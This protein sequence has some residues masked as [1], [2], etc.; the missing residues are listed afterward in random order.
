MSQSTFTGTRV[1]DPTSGMRALGRN[2]VEDFAKNMNYFAE[3]DALCHILKK[4]YKVK[5]V[6]VDMLERQ[7]GQSYFVSPLKSI[8]YM[9]AE[10]LS[11]LFVQW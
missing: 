10:V 4:H 9:L 6:Q 7:G 2:V 1:T 11:I 5:E 8:K 3:P